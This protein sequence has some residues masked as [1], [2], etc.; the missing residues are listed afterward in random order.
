MLTMSPVTLFIPVVVALPVETTVI[1]SMWRGPPVRAQFYS[2]V[3]VCRRRARLFPEA[4]AFTFMARASVAFL[5]DDLGFGLALGAYRSMAIGLKNLPLLVC[6]ASV[7]IR[8][9]SI[10]A[11]FNIGDQLRS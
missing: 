3:I 8:R 4:S 7:S 1:L 10:S 2:D 5:E 9:F 6:S 11:C